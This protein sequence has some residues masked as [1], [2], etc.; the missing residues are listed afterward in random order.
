MNKDEQKFGKSELDNLR[1]IA[2][3]LE[4]DTCK[5]IMRYIFQESSELERYPQ[6]YRE[7]FDIAFSQAVMI[8]QHRSIYLILK[9]IF[10]LRSTFFIIIL[11]FHVSFS[12]SLVNLSYIFNLCASIVG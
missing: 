2:D 7:R 5:H 1:I 6:A 11:F 8:L 3:E 9:I 10:R 4:H 12:F